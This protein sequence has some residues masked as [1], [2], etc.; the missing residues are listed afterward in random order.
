MLDLARELNQNG[1]DVKFYSYVPR[2]RA[3]KFGMDPK[4]VVSFFWMLFPFLALEHYTKHAKWAVNLRRWTLDSLCLLFM[5]RCDIIIS[6]SGE[7][8]RS[9][10]KVKRLGGYVII[11]RGSKHILEQKRILESIPSQKGKIVINQSNIDREVSDYNIADY[12]SIAAQHVKDSFIKYGFPE[13]KLFVNPYGVELSMFKPLPTINKEYDVIMVGTWCY[14]KGCDMLIEAIKKTNLHLIHV[15]GILDIPFPTHP[16]FTH[17]DK[18]DQTELIN[19]YNKSRVFVLPSREEGMA[20]V[21]AQ[22][23]SC[24]LPIVGSPDS[25]AA[26]IKKYINDSEYVSIVDPLTV[27]NIVEALNNAIEQSRKLFYKELYAGNGLQN[28]TW[29]AYGSR[30]ANFLN[31]NVVRR[32][33]GGVNLTS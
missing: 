10:R 22:A 9:N 18:V 33:L 12:I 23:V 19:Y 24:N 27:D 29:D 5:R 4:C 25:G 8:N 3:K 31:N 17:V 6:M 20:L 11:E 2:K 13:E 32:V 1:F 21:Q 15:G 26:D 30:Y 16:Q 28:L 14:R 7:F